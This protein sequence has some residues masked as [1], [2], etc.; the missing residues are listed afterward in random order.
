MKKAT[1]ILLLIGLSACYEG[2]DTRPRGLDSTPSPT[3]IP[4]PSPSATP[5][6]TPI[7]SPSPLP[8]S[9]QLYSG[10]IEVE[11]YVIKF[12]DDGKAQS[13]DVLPDM[14]KPMLEIKVASLNTYG[15]SVIGLC[16]SSGSLRRVTF[17][18]DFWNTANDTQR[19]LLAHHELGH[20]VLYRPHKSDKL[21][22]GEYGSIMYPIIM[23]PPTY[24]KNYNFYQQ[25]LFKWKSDQLNQDPDKPITHI[26]DLADL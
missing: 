7:P 24:N 10:P 3:P 22:S 11:K 18:P 2:G 26:C 1:S 5:T 21:P 4:S 23:T 25:E 12:V 9:G 8:P 14:K 13:V 16:E 19:E 6:P 17:D 20:C 15:A